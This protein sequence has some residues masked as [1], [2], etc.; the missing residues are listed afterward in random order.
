MVCFWI[1]A[2]KLTFTLATF[3]AIGA[4]KSVWSLR[5]WWRSS[6]ETMLI[7]GAAAAI[8]FIVGTFFHV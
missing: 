7:G 2:S 5:A 6:L 4:F 1:S 8:A 3:Y